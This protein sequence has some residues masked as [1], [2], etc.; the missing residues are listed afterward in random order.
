RLEVDTTLNQ[1]ARARYPDDRA[2]RDEF[3]RQV[4]KLN[5]GMFPDKG[6]IGSIRLPAGTVLRLPAE[7]ASA[8]AVALPRVAPPAP[9]AKPQQAASATGRAAATDRLVISAQAFKGMN[10]R[11]VSQELERLGLISAEQARQFAELEEKLSKLENTFASLGKDFLLLQEKLDQ[12]EAG[13]LAAEEERKQAL[14]QLASERARFGVWEILALIL[15]GGAVGAAL[16]FYHDRLRSRRQPGWADAAAWGR[17]TPQPDAQPMASGAQAHPVAPA[18]PPAAAPPQKEA[19]LPVPSQ[20]VGAARAEPA[21]S[22]GSPAP[23]KDR[24]L[25]P[26][27]G[28]WGTSQ[29]H[30]F[31]LASESDAELPHYDP[32][33][34]PAPTL[35]AEASPHDM[36]MELAEVMASM[37]LKQGAAETLIEHI[38][39]HPRETMSHWLKLLDI[40]HE[41]DL[42]GQLSASVAELKGKFNVDFNE[43]TGQSSAAQQSLLDYQHLVSN[44]VRV[45]N[46]DECEEFLINLMLDTRDGTRQGFPRAVVEEIILLRAIA[47]ERRK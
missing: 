30:A 29:P 40:Y 17:E 26:S 23:A 27:P 7:T 14:A 35:S 2:A 18:V 12:I 44:L 20:A 5:P 19:P 4:A 38:R 46:S 25:Q 32:L 41:A 36:A 39:T 11:E 45:W 16:L 24:A 33:W 9:V 43:W 15:T 6:P 13:R 21:L 8:G 28:G 34:N 1:L 10:A 42:S 31:T 47:E 22:G 3:R 37:G